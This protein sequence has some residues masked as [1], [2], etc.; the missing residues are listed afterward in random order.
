MLAKDIAEQ[1]GKDEIFITGGGEIYKQ[2]LPNTQRLYVT[3]LDREYEGHVFFPEINWD[4]WNI[5]HEEKHGADPEKD[6]PS[7]TFYTLERKA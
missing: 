5:A 4:E 6:R 7:F 2:T 1:A 3:V